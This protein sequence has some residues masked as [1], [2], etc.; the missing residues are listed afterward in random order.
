MNESRNTAQDGSGGGRNAFAPVVN[1]ARNLC[2]VLLLIPLASH[3]NNQ[4]EPDGA[5]STT[6]DSSALSAFFHEPFQKPLGYT[7]FLSDAK[8]RILQRFGKPTKEMSTQYPARTSDELIWSTTLTYSGITLVVGESEDRSKSWLESID[9]R[10]DEHILAH[11]LRVGSPRT[12]VEL[13]FSSSHF[14]EYD[15][16]IRFGT[17]IYEFR[18]EVTLGTAME[19][20]VDI[21]LDGRVTRFMI[22]SIEL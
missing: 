20:R 8:E 4:S 1:S 12:D 21:G 15:G 19:L 10:T 3:S 9:V 6:A 17:E 7:F 18:G 13:A 14:I 16:G 2:W 5:I 22:E 11:G